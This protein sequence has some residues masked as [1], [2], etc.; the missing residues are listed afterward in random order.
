[1]GTTSS[2]IATVT[3]GVWS[4]HTVRIEGEAIHE[5][6]L[7][8]APRRQSHESF[9]GIYK[10]VRTGGAMEVNVG[11]YLLLGDRTWS[12]RGGN[13]YRWRVGRRHR[14]WS[15]YGGC[16]YRRRGTGTGTTCPLHQRAVPV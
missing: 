16:A 6:W 4:H 9:V 13:A 15:Q 10:G 7:L 11:A 1:M 2:H 8:G 12:Q 14:A 5:E 3:L